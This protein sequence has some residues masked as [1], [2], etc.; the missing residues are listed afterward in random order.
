MTEATVTRKSKN[1]KAPKPFADE[2]TDQLLAQIQNGDA[3]SIFGES[4]VAWQL[5]KQPAERILGVELT[6]YL[7]SEVEQRHGR[8]SSQ[9]EQPEDRSDAQWEIEAGYST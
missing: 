1:Q 4:G 6:H 8:Q 2:L 5:K 3:E 9:R 7:E